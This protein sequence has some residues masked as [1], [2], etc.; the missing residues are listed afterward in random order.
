[1]ESLSEIHNHWRFY[2]FVENLSLE[3]I[4]AGFV[5]KAFQ[6]ILITYFFKMVFAQKYTVGVP[7][8]AQWVKYSIAV[9]QVTAEVWVLSTT[10]ELP[11][12]AGEA[13]KRSILYI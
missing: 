12:A 13:I 1:M 2:C 3:G 7:A 10:W 5:F 8:V 4:V 6:H 11:Y 9:A